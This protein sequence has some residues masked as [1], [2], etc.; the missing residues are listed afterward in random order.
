[1]ADNVVLDKLKHHSHQAN[2]SPLLQL[3]VF[4][5]VLLCAPISTQA[6][7]KTPNTRELSWD[8]KRYID[9][10]EINPGMEAYCLTCYEGTRIEKFNLDV[11]SVLRGYSPGHDAILVQGTDERFIHTGIVAG[12][13]GSPV[14]INRRMAGALAFG[15]PFG[16]DP[17]YG[18]TP[19]REMLELGSS[20]SP[21]AGGNMTALRHHALSDWDFKAPI[22][23]SM[24]RMGPGAHQDPTFASNPVGQRFQVPLAISGLP[25]DAVAPISK[26]LGPF[27]L[28][29]VPNIA[30]EVQ[31]I[32]S[33]HF[34][35][36]ASLVIPLVSGDINMSVLGT[37]TEVRDSQIFGFGHS[38]LGIGPVDIPMATGYVHT[39][40]SSIQRSFKLGSAL[41]EVGA[42]RTDGSTGIVGLMDA[43]APTLPLTLRITHFSRNQQQVYRCRLAYH[44][45]LTPDLLNA[46][47]QGA[48][49]GL[50]TLPPEHTLTYQGAIRLHTNR[51]IRFGNVSTGIGLREILSESIGTALLLMDNPYREMPIKAIELDVSVRPVSKLARISSITVSDL[52]VEAGDRV[53]VSVVLEAYHTEKKRYDF[54]I[55]VPKLLKPGSYQLTVCGTPDYIQHIRRLASHR[56]VAMDIP[57]LLDA[58]DYVLSIQRDQLFCLFTL[59]ASGVIV[60]R[61]ELADLPA[62]KSMV[63]QNAKRT[64]RMQP[65]VPWLETS[66][67]VERVVV[68]RHTA[69]ISVK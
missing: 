58:L 63:L 18:V 8:P 55:T 30:G 40:V 11:I 45:L 19:I 32:A 17:L 33:T 13:S 59:P 27:G 54:A 22:D 29:A 51:L 14:Y 25:T 3:I 2:S 6:A 60:E 12:C 62:S 36:G 69:K 23:F 16:K 44:K 49:L 15:W 47:I 34:T 66:Q 10:D 28:T 52:H 64:V 7:D 37:V 42:L 4:V 41:Q 38:F 21:R 43:K 5:G 35:P 39:V 65:Y 50:G 1:M 46:T 68:N 9:V 48:V 53:Q 24:L 57:S 26:V 31:G 61:N 20:P 67:S 56:M